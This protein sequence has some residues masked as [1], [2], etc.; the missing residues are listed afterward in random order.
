MFYLTSSH[1]RCGGTVLSIERKIGD[2]VKNVGN[3]DAMDDHVNT[4][5]GGEEQGEGVNELERELQDAEEEDLRESEE[6]TVLPV[7]SDGEEDDGDMDTGFQRYLDQMP[8]DNSTYVTNISSGTCTCPDRVVV[9]F[10]CKHLFRALELAGKGFDSLPKSVRE[11][12]HLS[13]DMD[14]IHRSNCVMEGVVERSAE[15]ERDGDGGHMES[16]RGGQA[17]E[18]ADFSESPDTDTP[19]PATECSNIE[20]RETEIALNS[21]LAH[22]KV[23]TSLAHKAQLVG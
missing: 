8:L 17:H 12:P 16:A 20:T 5:E 21:L 7:E 23:M 3:V 11:A 10:V 22:L 18:K 13:I 19:A 4:Q 1:N 15:N 2:Y 14:I 9:G 6:H